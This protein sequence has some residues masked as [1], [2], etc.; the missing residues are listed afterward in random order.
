MKATLVGA[1]TQRRTQ[2]AYLQE[3]YQAAADRQSAVIGRGGAYRKLYDLMTDASA[4]AGNEYS[5]ERQCGRHTCGTKTMSPAQE[6]AF[7]KQVAL[8][9]MRRVRQYCGAKFPVPESP[10]ASRRH[11]SRAP[12]ALPLGVL[13]G[14]SKQL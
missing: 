5:V 13:P 14:H 4:A 11:A 1:R 2:S 7:G 8:A 10:N 12:P 9:A 3:M 6:L